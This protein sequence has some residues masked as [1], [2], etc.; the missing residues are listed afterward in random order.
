METSKLLARIMGPVMIVQAIGIV[1]NLAEFQ[2]IYEEFSKSPSLCY[3]GGLMAFLLAL[4]VLQF[5]NRW[6]A[7][8]PVLITIVSW[9]ALIKGLILI[10][11]PGS[12]LILWQPFMASPTPLIISMIISGAVG[13]FL[14]I[15]GYWG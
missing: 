3:L 10:L 5:H 13:V 4:L 8:W 11:F 15:K 1:I 2:R 9:I 12:V 6:E 14:T 7:G